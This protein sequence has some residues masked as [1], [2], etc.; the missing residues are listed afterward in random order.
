MMES[1]FSVGIERDEE[2]LKKNDNDH[3]K[4]SNP[5]ESRLVL[6]AYLSNEMAEY[7]RTIR[8]RLPN[9]PSMKLFCIY[10]HGKETEVHTSDF[11]CN[12]RSLIIASCTYKRS[13]WYSRGEYEHDDTYADVIDAKCPE[14]NGTECNTTPR[15]PLDMPLSRRNWIDFEMTNEKGWPKVS[16]DLGRSEWLSAYMW[17]SMTET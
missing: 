12:F 11:W 4:W 3:R 8:V 2:V 14:A 17:V 7:T 5:L 16:Y 1:N 13:Y 9:A 10:G 15:P 6:F